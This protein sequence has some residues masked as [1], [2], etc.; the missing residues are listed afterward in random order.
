MEKSSMNDEPLCCMQQIG[1]LAYTFDIFVKQGVKADG[2]KY[3]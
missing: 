2:I 3:V 1:H